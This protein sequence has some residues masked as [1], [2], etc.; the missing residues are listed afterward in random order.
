MN[1]L[2]IIFLIILI[3]CTKQATLPE[4]EI[5][6]E[7]IEVRS[8]PDCDDAN[9]CT[10]DSCSAD[11]DYA[12]IH[13]EITP[14]C[15]NSIC[16]LNESHYTCD[17]CPRCESADCEISKFDYDQ[18]KCVREAVIPCCGNGACEV[19]ETSD[20]ID[21]PKCETTDD[22]MTSEFD[23]E[24]GYCVVKP[25]V[26]CCGNNICDRGE[27]CESCSDCECDES[28]D[29]SDFPDFLQD[30]TL[31]VVGDTAT[32]QDTFTATVLTTKLFTQGVETSANLYSLF[33]SGDL[34][35]N[36][37]I[38]LGRP[39]ENSLWEEYQ[40]V[41]CGDDNYFNT[42][43]AIIKLIID[44]NREIIYVAGHSPDDTEEAADRLASGS[45]SGMEVEI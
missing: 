12:C 33:D 16:E 38:V 42:G 27:S 26:P 36:D 1:K 40:G 5:K 44:G 34:A 29:L 7:I 14:C 28:L 22:C 30:G 23:Y 18:Q 32:S 31:I 25:I 20:C 9:P 10:V 37:L 39:C 35:T 15:G 21:C 11:T 13:D 24:K 4:A 41:E 43:E 19:S 45:L 17:D 8:C 6:E 3:G 2:I